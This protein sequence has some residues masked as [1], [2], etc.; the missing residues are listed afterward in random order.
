MAQIKTVYHGSTTLFNQIDV[1]QGKPYKD[2]GRGFYV[3]ENPNH[4]KNLALRNKRIETERYGHNAQAYLYTYTLDLA[5]CKQMLK[6]REFSTADESWMGFVLN[7]RKSRGCDHAYDMV[8]G[9][10]ADDVTSL[11]LK[12]Y[13][14][15]L[16]GEVNT[17]HAIATAIRLI[18][19]DKLPPQIF[20]ATNAA[21]AYLQQQGDVRI[22]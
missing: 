8:L 17:S 15:G 12:A 16:Y 1:T 9:P 6:V 13:F 11:V 22:L 18:E 5:Q 21:A 3:T 7:N 19:A 2:F 10:T 4:G 14:D 20:F